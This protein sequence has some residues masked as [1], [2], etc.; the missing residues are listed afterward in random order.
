MHVD[1]VAALKMLGLVG[2]FKLF[3]HA[4]SLVGGT[5]TGIEA[6]SNSLPILRE[7]RVATAK[8]T[9][10]YLA[11]S[12]AITAGGLL[13]CYLLWDI[14]KPEGE[15]RTMD[16]L[17]AGEVAKHLPF[18]GTFVVL[19]LASEA[20]L[21]IVAA[22]AGFLG[23]PRVLANMAVD[24]WMPHAFSSISERLIT[25]NGTAIMAGAALIALLVTAG[26]VDTLVVMYS[27]NVFLTF[28]LTMLGMIRF[29]W[30]QPKASSAGSASPCSAPARLYFVL[31]VTSVEKFAEGAWLTIW[32]RCCWWCCARSSAGTTARPRGAPSKPTASS[33]ACRSRRGPP[34][35]WRAR[36][37]PRSSPGRRLRRAGHPHLPQR[38]ARLPGHYKQVVFV[39]VGVV[40]SGTYKGVEAVDELSLKTEEVLSRY[41]RLATAMKLPASSMLAVGIDAVEEAEKACLAVAQDY[42]RSV[43]FAGKLIFEHER[44]YHRL[45]HNN[46]AIVLAACTGAARRC[47]SC[48]RASSSTSTTAARDPAPATWARARATA[49]GPTLYACACPPHPRR[50]GPGYR[51]ARHRGLPPPP[52]RRLPPVVARPS[53]ARDGGVHQRPRHLRVGEQVDPCG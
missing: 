26:K 42:P 39:S 27:I 46:S 15:E 34:L 44:W 45:L 2:I 5:Y 8:R 30:R 12:L 41:V 49:L 21:L 20:V 32:S 1:L 13:V 17:L 31:V 14:H 35:R 4:Y 7:P 23:G 19:T 10:L 50:T 52:A 47:A 16:A 48:P 9:M 38:R 36:T 37:P 11:T 28:T 43:F 3:A 29:W 22:Q 53:R 40:D 51:R 25:G 33:G 18:G 24:S 6:V